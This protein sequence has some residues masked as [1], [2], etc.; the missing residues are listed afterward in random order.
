LIREIKKPPAR[1]FF[2]NS[3]DVVSLLLRHHPFFHR[4]WAGKSEVKVKAEKADVHD[5]AVE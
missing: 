2:R 4:R 5:D 3:V 1:R